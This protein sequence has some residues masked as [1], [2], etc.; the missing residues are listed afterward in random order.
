MYMVQSGYM[1]SLKKGNTVTKKLH[2][3][4]EIGKK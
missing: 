2:F 1:Q 4:R 3:D